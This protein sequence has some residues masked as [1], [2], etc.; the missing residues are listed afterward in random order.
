LTDQPSPTLPLTGRVALV[1]GSSSGIGAA[2]ATAL[3]GQGAAVVVNSSRSTEVGEA[4]AAR[5]G[6]IYVQAD[7]SDDENARRLVDTAV[8]RH[9]RLDIVVNSAGITVAIPHDDLEAVTDDIWRT[10][11]DVNILGTWHVIRAAVPHLKASGAGNIVNVTSRAGSRPT[12]SSVPYAATKAALDHITRLL[13]RALG[14]DI[15]VNAVAPGLV[16]TPWT[17]GPAFD[18]L[19]AEV[20]ATAPLGRVGEADDVA[21]MVLALVGSTYVTGEVVK[22]DGG[23]HLT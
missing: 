15:R 19:R 2:I 6:G 22:V 1:T 18:K 11:F 9:G 10:I 16:D 23:M 12:G 14:P 20:M 21:A 4:L 8:E 13:A 5:I 17:E 7:V 3:A